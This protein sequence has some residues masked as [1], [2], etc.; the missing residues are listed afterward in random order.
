MA[1]EGKDTISSKAW[2]IKCQNGQTP[3]HMERRKQFVK[4]TER[5]FSPKVHE[6]KMLKSL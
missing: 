2:V 6:C 1:Y 3:L 5:A 4:K